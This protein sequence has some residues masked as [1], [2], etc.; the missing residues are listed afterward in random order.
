MTTL[1]GQVAQFVGAIDTATLP[2]RSI[3]AART[4][5]TDCVGVMIAGAGEPAPRIV[6]KFVPAS[7]SNEGAPEIPSGRNLSAPDAALVN[8]VAAHVLDY[9]DVALAGHPST[10]LTP[11]ILAE[12]W[13]RGS[14]GA[15][16]LAAYVAGYE[17]WALLLSREPGAL[18]DRGFHPTALYGAPAAAAACARL[19]GLDEQRTAHA[20]A[21]SASMAAGLVANFGTMTKSFHAGRAAQSGVIAARLASEGFTAS[22]D[23][24]EHRTG[25]LRAISPSGSP[26]LDGGDAQLGTEWRMPRAGVN[27]KRYPTCYSTHR[28]IDAMLDLANE[29][30]L[31]PDAVKEIR[32][33]TGAVQMLMLRNSRPKTGLE[34]KFSMEFAMAAALVARRVGLSELTD[35]FVA[36]PE[37]VANLDKVT[38]TT[39][40]DTVPELAM[41]PNDRVS[42]VLTD[43]R[44]IEHAPVAFA[45]GSWQ[46]PLTRDE[47]QEKFLDCATRRLGRAHA[48]ALFDQLWNITELAC[49][50]DLRVTELPGSRA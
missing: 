36:R 38:C 23:A 1:A 27:V 50:R 13:T 41:A 47:L 9:D 8:G 4:G 21:L 25:F 11:A 45:K 42:I 35:E 46:R 7:T 19:N 32:V 29:H 17:L 14:S 48:R 31:K 39:V 16:L 22:P 43:G 49:V 12:G 18:H 28:A 15:E 30:D 24:I 40:D 2:Q 6:A 20:I 33:Q 26:H 37:V 34:A 44:V 5:I 10:V 3:D